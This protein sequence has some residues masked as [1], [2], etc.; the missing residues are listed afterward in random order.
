[1]P[2]NSRKIVQ[3]QLILVFLRELLQTLKTQLK[4]SQRQRLHMKNQIELSHLRATQKKVKR[5]QKLMGS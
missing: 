4:S 2:P 5:L 1:M 3:L